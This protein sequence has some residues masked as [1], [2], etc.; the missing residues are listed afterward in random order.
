MECPLVSTPAA[1]EEPIRAVHRNRPEP[2]G[3]AARASAD[4]LDQTSRAR[5]RDEEKTIKVH[6]RVEPHAPE[7]GRR[8][9]AD[10]LALIRR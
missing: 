10:G 4:R 1:L 9:D 6:P 5:R 2:R 3:L 7:D 8:L